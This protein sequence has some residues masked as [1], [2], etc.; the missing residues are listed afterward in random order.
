MGKEHPNY[1]SSLSNLAL[2]YH[3]MG[4]YEKAEPLFLEAIVIQE[5]ALGKEHPGYANSLR[6]LAVLYHSMGQYEKSR[7]SLPRSQSHP[8]KK[9][10]KKTIPNMPES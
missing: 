5:K 1:A 8:G 2:L 6:N 7:T 9:P 10:W 4:G 3:S